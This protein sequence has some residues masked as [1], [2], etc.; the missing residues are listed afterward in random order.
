MEPGIKDSA[1][2][3]EHSETPEKLGV[4]GHKYLGDRKTAVC[5]W[6]ISSTTTNVSQTMRAYGPTQNSTATAALLE[7]KLVYS[8]C[9]RYSG[10]L[11]LAGLGCR[12]CRGSIIKVLIYI[13]NLLVEIRA[14][15]NRQ[16]LRLSTERANEGHAVRA[17]C[18]SLRSPC[19]MQCTCCT[20]AVKTVDKCQTLAKF[21]ESR[22]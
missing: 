20:T 21:E 9:V 11:R 16:R 4:G 7:V 1:V 8:S 18:A 19:I 17:T 15:Y 12:C 3:D 6:V 2:P 13:I 10:R 14:D 22:R 5:P